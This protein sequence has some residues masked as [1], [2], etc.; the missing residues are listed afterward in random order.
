M[1]IIVYHKKL[2]IKQL[3][4]LLKC[5]YLSHAKKYYLINYNIITITQN[6]IYSKCYL[7]KLM[8]IQIL[9]KIGFIRVI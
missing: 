3:Q 5:H 4:I 6:I 2:E 8:S 9:S 7:N 1:S